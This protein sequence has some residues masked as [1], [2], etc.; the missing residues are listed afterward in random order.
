MRGGTRLVA[1]TPVI[2]S[3]YSYLPRSGIALW[4]GFKDVG[5]LYLA[6]QLGARWGAIV[7][8]HQA[9]SG[10]LKRSIPEIKQL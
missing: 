6:A 8:P 5:Q 2:L 7:G 3:V 4:L 10:R 9:M 1:A